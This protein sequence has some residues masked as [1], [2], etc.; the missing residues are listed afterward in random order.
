M[1][2]VPTEAVEGSCGVEL[3]WRTADGDK[4]LLSFEKYGRE[5]LLKLASAAVVRDSVGDQMV[6][7]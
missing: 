5:Y 2:E 3:R 1:L 6:E 4:T 7:L